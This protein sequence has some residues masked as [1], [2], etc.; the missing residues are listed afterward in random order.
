MRLFGTVNAVGK[1]L[2][3]KWVDDWIFNVCA[4]I[5]DYPKNNFRHGICF[6]GTNENEDN[7]RNWNYRSEEHTSELQSPQ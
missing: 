1:T 7:Y 5:E 6:R 4:V 3:Y 2:K